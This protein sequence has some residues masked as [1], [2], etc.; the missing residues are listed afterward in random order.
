MRTLSFFPRHFILINSLFFFPPP[1]ENKARLEDE[2]A[3]RRLEI[4]RKDEE[5]VRL[6]TQ[7]G[8]VSASVCEFEV[9]FETI[10]MYS[11]PLPILL[12]FF[13]RVVWCFG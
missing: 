3:R 9:I 7:G 2:L 8:A 1:K 11:F 5:I 10:T 12:Y 4:S 6:Q 13:Y